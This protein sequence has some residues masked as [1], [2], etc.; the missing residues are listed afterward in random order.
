MALDLITDP[1]G[2][3]RQ[4]M[5]TRVARHLLRWE[6]A[7]GNI[8]K[9]PGGGEGHLPFANIAL[10]ILMSIWLGPKANRQSIHPHTDP[11][12]WLPTSFTMCE[13]KYL[14]IYK[15]WPGQTTM[16]AH[17]ES[18]IR[19]PGENVSASPPHG[20]AHT[21]TLAGIKSSPGSEGKYIHNIFC[22]ASA[23]F[24]SFMATLGWENEA[25]MG[26][27]NFRG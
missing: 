12:R 1:Q 23:R 7:G 2:Q 15:S 13:N 19:N 14:I 25:I 8:R 26:G 21:D 3:G 27:R 22:L 4:A 5:A 18:R 20:W 24:K 6:E 16:T 10:L 17:P 11:H 9:I